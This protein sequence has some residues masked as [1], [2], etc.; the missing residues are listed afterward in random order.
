MTTAPL[1]MD[2]TDAPSVEDLREA[3]GRDAHRNV[4]DEGL[5]RRHPSGAD[6]WQRLPA[7]PA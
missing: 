1:Q 2:G 5:A 7:P 6:Y 4:A 3:L